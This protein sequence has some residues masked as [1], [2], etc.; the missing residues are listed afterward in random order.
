MARR[1]KDNAIDWDAIEKKY[2][3]GVQSN[4]QL[5]EEFGIQPSSLG[6]RA[7]KYGWVQDKAKDVEAVRNSLLIQSASGK[8]NP[9]ATPNAIEVQV[10]AK[11]TA[12]VV[13][14]HRVGLQRQAAIESKLLNQLEDA[15][16]KMGSLDELAELLRG[17]IG[18]DQSQV[19]KAMR[20]LGMIADRGNLVDDFKKLVE[21]S[22][23][24][25][26]GEREAFG[27]DA[28]GDKPTFEYEAMLKRVS[29][30]KK[31]RAG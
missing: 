18:D 26:K 25:R 11:A 3:L 9:N 4:K 24:R 10:A 22:D 19:T 6:R 28:E 17:G 15:V 16:D 7:E 8:S 14:S 23:K 31:M 20:M 5:A 1:S 21:A 27:I 12:D 29:E 13:L 2:R 30:L